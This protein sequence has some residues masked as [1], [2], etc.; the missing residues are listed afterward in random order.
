L[1][2]VD[3]VYQVTQLQQL[4]TRD[5][6]QVLVELHPQVVELEQP[7]HLLLVLLEVLEVLVEVPVEVLLEYLVEQEIHLQ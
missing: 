1:E 5:Q 6:I 3:Q 2:E 7:Q 4:V